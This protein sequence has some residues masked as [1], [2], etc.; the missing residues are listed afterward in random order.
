MQKYRILIKNLSVAS[1]FLALWCNASYAQ[2]QVG[3]NFGFDISNN[4]LMIDIAPTI[5]MSPFEKARVTVSPFFSHIQNV[6]VAGTGV[7]RLG[8]RAALQYTIFTGLFAH[9]E[10][11][12][13]FE[14][15]N[16]AYQGVSH[17]LPIGAG[18]EYEIAPNTVAYGMALYNVLHNS[19]KSSDFR[20]TPFQ[21]RVGVRYSL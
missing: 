17:A 20:E 6:Q 2:V 21:Y 7:S 15:A 9:A 10:Y 8:L 18:F 11:E 12:C 14:R 4:V 1:L 19:P 5:G 16:D 13:A 3:G